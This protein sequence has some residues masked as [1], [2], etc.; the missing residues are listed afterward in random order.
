MLRVIRYTHDRAREWNGFVED[1]KNGTFLF[2]RE[3]MDYH[4]DRFC[5]HSLMLYDCT[6]RN[7]R[8]KEKLVA[9]LPANEREQ[10]LR[11]H[12]GLTYG[13]LILSAKTHTA[14]VGEMFAAITE[15]AMDNGF[16]SLRYKKIPQVYHRLPADEDDYWLWRHGA[17]MTACAVMTVVDLQ[18]WCPQMVAQTRR[19][20]CHRLEREGYTMVKDAPITDFWP[21][22][23]GNLKERYGASPVHTLDEIEKLKALF[24]ENIICCTL[25]NQEGK[26]VAGTLLYVSGQVVKTQYISASHEGKACN[27]L[28]YLLLSIIAQCAENARYRYFDFGTSMLEDGKNFNTGLLQQKESYGGRTMTSCVYNL[29]LSK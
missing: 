28:D 27:A 12:D 10:M 18:K 1:S 7:G 16:T 3:Y 5:D 14:Q 23:V 29:D 4:S 15:Y 13:G 6:E 22:L 21:L 8:E 19:T 17:E 20:T 26:T 11:S 9:L 24:P 25:K 2:L